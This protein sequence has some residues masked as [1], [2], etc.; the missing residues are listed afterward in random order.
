LQKQPEYSI[1][2]VLDDKERE[3][4]KLSKSKR[5]PGH[6]IYFMTSVTSNDV[7]KQERI[8]AFD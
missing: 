3:Q 7:L 6:S 1:T 5:K 4:I 8:S 2:E